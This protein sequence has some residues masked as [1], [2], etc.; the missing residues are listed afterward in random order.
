VASIP[1]A[2][3]DEYLAQLPAERRA[4]VAAVRAMVR[5]HLPKGYEERPAWGMITYSVPLERTGPTYNGQPLCYA[6]LAAQKHHYSLYLMGAYMNPVLTKRLQELFASAGRK[7]DMGKSCVRFKTLD[8]IPLEGLGEVIAAVPVDTFVSRYQAVH[9][10]TKSGSKR[11]PKQ[12]TK[13]VA[14]AKGARAKA[15][16]AARKK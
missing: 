15:T 9:G 14:K 12:T 16:K 6:A 3:V 4:V 1:A 10:A 8:A 13:S 5:K 7:L 2:T 11:S